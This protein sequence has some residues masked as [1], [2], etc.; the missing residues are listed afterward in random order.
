MKKTCGALVA[1]TTSIALLTPVYGLASNNSAAPFSPAQ[2]QQIQ[3]IVHDYL[4]NNPEVLIEASQALQNKEMLKAKDQA[5]QGIQTNKQKLFSDGHSPTAGNPNG[6]VI[7]VE[8]F[9]YQCGHCKEMQPSIEKLVG[10]NSNVKI[11]YKEFPIFGASSNY[12]S[13]MALASVKQ[14]KYQ[15]FHNALF[16]VSGPLSEAKVDEI[17]KSVGLN[18]D[19]LKKDMNDPVVKQEL[20]TTYELAKALNLVGTPSFVL[21]NKAM[22]QFDFIPGAAPPKLFQQA[23]DNIAKK[24]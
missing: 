3:Q 13:Q 9:D 15:E 19:Q 10:S 11:I 4:V 1:L 8:F 7:L 22:T 14:N 2:T 16:K 17:A 23:V 20:Q 5:M 24:Q 21:S 6:D 18:V 12:A